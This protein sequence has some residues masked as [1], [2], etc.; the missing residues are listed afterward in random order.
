[1][2]SYFSNFHPFCDARLSKGKTI[3]M[4]T[5]M[6]LMVALL[7]ATAAFSQGSKK[8]LQNLSGTYTS[9]QGEDWGRGTFGFRTFSFADGRWALTFQLALDPDMKNQVFEFR[10]YGTY[11]VLE[12]AKGLEAYEALFYENEKF[13][14]LLTEDQE[15]IKNFG[16]SSCEL[17]PFVEQNISAAGCA[18]WPSVSDC[19]EDHDLLAMDDSGLLYFGVRPADNNMCTADRRPTALLPPVRLKNAQTVNNQVK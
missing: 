7:M 4:K 9:I 17:E 11:E 3:T 14:T 1:L 5:M 18:L 8:K 13:L 10:T 19:N 2:T 12:K 15:L 16:L 6:T